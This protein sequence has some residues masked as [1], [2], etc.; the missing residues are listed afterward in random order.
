MNQFLSKMKA[1]QDKFE[2][3]RW[4]KDEIKLLDECIEAGLYASTLVRNK[5]FNDRSHASIANMMTARK[6]WKKRNSK[7]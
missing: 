1:E 7:N 6:R 4:T 3:K 5:I 2:K